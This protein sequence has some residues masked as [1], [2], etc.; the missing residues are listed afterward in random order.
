M[1]VT[2][3]ELAKALGVSTRTLERW[4]RAGMPVL[5]QRAAYGRPRY[6][7]AACRKWAAER[8]TQGR[9]NPTRPT[10][11]TPDTPDTPTR[12]PGPWPPSARGRGQ[13]RAHPRRTSREGPRNRPRN[14]A[15]PAPRGNLLTKDEVETEWTRQGRA[16]CAAMLEVPRAAV[17]IRY[18]GVEGLEDTCR[19]LNRRCDE[20]PGGGLQG[21]AGVTW[22]LPNKARS[23]RLRA[24]QPAAH[25]D[26][27]ASP[28][29][30]D[31][32][33]YETPL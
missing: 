6:D 22:Y 21:E 17:A 24:P 2:Q 13:A 31:L 28:H 32:S 3:T 10:S 11:E 8:P 33:H 15:P 5:A 1:P 9:R 25:I 18:P 19:H 23:V 16:V 29:Q 12:P 14:Q 7:I 30:R 4:A 20:A 27:D 26:C